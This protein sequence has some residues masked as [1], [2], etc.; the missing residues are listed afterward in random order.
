VGCCN[1]V[2]RYGVVRDGGGDRMLWDLEMP[3]WLRGHVESLCH[4]VV[5]W[6]LDEVVLVKVSVEQEMVMVP[7]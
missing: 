3:E 4:C 6:M 5:R 2:N 1:V 7:V